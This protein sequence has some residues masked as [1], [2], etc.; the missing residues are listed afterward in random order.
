[1]SREAEGDRVH[2]D[3]GHS[4][5]SAGSVDLWLAKLKVTMLDG[6]IVSDRV[7]GETARTGG[8]LNL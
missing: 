3:R 1:M 2:L 6:V 7:V 8:S 4:K 5:F